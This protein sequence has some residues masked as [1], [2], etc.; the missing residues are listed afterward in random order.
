MTILETTEKICQ[1]NARS[2]TVQ[3]YKDKM[4]IIMK[5]RSMTKEDVEAWHESC[6]RDAHRYFNKMYILG[7][8]EDIKNI[9]LLIMNDINIEFGQFML[10]A[11]EKN[12]FIGMMNTILDG[13]NHLHINVDFLS[14]IFLKNLFLL[15]LMVY[16]FTLFMPYGGELM[17]AFIRHVMCIVGGVSVC[18]YLKDQCKA[19]QCKAMQSKAKQNQNNIKV[20]ENEL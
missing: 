9:R 15:L 13:F 5:S 19:M 12:I 10:M 18:I 4:I 6:I 14:N 20:K 1:E 11:C 7:K 2:K 17:S 16:I 8:D 3:I